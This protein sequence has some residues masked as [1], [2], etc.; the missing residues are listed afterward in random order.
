M[1]KVKSFILATIMGIVGVGATSVN[2][3]A[4]FVLNENCKLWYKQ[5]QG[6]FEC[7]P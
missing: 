6:F 7:A 2:V 1:K 4:K 3:N 5:S